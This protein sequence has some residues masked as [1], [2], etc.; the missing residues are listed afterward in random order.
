[1]K[2][3]LALSFIPLLTLASQAQ[4]QQWGQVYFDNSV[5][6]QAPGDRLVRT[7]DGSPVVGTYHAAQLYYG[8]NIANL[9]PLTNPPATFPPPGTRRAGTWIGGMRTLVG[10]PPGTQIVLQVRFWH[11]D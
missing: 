10:I 6:F 5:E 9:I 7:F 3:S 2:S 4:T 11:T 1:M 8:T